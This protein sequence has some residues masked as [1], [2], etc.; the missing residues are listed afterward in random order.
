MAQAL[1][2][3]RTEDGRP[4]QEF[5]ISKE[6]MKNAIVD[7]KGFISKIAK[8]LGCS[9]S[10]I[11]QRISGDEELGLLLKEVKEGILDRLEDN[12][13]EEALERDEWKDAGIEE[14]RMIIGL[15]KWLLDRKAR[16]R[17]YGE[18]SGKHPVSPEIHINITPAIDV[19]P[20]VEVEVKENVEEAEYEEI[21]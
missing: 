2:R 13:L 14:R 1:I 8:S 17:G 16:S 19:K 6:D 11:S 12:L 21:G 4:P 7:C 3:R 15:H 9:P 18:Q 20:A 10:N 5:S